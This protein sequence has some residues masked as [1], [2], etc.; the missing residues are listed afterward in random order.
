MSERGYFLY[1]SDDA[2]ENMHPKSVVVASTCSYGG[3]QV[4]REDVR[5]P[6]GW[7]VIIEPMDKPSPCRRLLGGRRP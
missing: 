4:T 2:G 7:T 1:I 5:V 6:E 3:K